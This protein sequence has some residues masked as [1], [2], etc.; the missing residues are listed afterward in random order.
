MPKRPARPVVSVEA[1]GLRSVFENSIVEESAAEEAGERCR[2]GSSGVK[3]PEENA[4]FMSCL[5]ARPTILG[6][7]SATCEAGLNSGHS[8]RD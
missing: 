7:F 6:T 1:V 5:K 4:T 2:F 3:T 8:Q